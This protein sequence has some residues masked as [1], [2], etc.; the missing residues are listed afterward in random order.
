[1]TF[2]EDDILFL[3]KVINSL[4]E[5]FGKDIYAA[6]SLHTLQKNTCNLFRLHILLDI[7]HIFCIE[8]TSNF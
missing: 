6:F 7:I 2:Y 8:K 1:M 3:T 4:D 5:V